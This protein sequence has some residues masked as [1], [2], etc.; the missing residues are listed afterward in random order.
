MALSSTQFQQLDEGLRD[1]FRSHSDLA[2]MLRFETGER[3]EDLVGSGGQRQVVFDL[4]DYFDAQGRID[5]LIQG[6][7]RQNPGNEVLR[8]FYETSGSALS[9]PPKRELQD[10]IRGGGGF[11]DPDPFIRWAIETGPRV[12]RV[13]IDSDLGPIW[14]TG[15][16]MGPDLLISNYHVLEAVIRGSRGEVTES[17]N[18]S[19]SAG[20]AFRFDYKVLSDGTTINSGTVH[21]LGDG[22]VDQW[23]VDESPPSPIDVLADPGGQVP[24]DDELD[25]A[26][27]RLE[28]DAARDDVP[29]LGGG[30]SKRGWIPAPG[31]LR[32]LPAESPLFILQHPDHLPQKWA[33]DPDSVIASNRT[34]VTYRTNTLSGSSGAPCFDRR[35][36]FVALHHSGDPNFEHQRNEGIPTQALLLRLT[37][38]GISLPVPES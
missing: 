34:R 5:E 13:E 15:F 19:S 16:L 17:G 10:L 14:G 32:D 22:S 1:A 18:R 8:N 33:Y 23:L 24:S 38:Q 28:T 26:L 11:I 20:V 29:S 12:C 35:M 2:R 3:L 37:A 25:F 31:P 4:I 6:A 27:V 21:H 7:V 30:T 36:Q 9:L